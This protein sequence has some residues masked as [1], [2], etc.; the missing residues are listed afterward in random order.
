MPID[1]IPVAV[2]LPVNDDLVLTWGE[3]TEAGVRLMPKALG[4]TR[5]GFG[6]HRGRFQNEA[7]AERWARFTKLKVTHWTPLNPPGAGS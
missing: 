5:F 2:R 6:P 7:E 1:W 4:I 3:A